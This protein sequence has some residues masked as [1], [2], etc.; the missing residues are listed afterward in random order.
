LRVLTLA[1]IISQMGYEHKE[2]SGSLFRNEQKKS[3]NH[4]D[5]T[6]KINFKGETLDLSGWI[7]DTN[8]KK[9]LSLS[10]REPRQADA[11]QSSPTSDI[12]F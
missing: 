11:S 1:E 7:K 2:N 9:W 10:L 6:G 4:P 8:G 5:Y 3:D 12:P